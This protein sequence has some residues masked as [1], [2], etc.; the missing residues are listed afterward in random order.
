MESKTDFDN[1]L[2]VLVLE[3][4]IKEQNSTI[5]NMKG[6]INRLSEESEHNKINKQVFLK[7]ADS[8]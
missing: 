6:T 7:R 3:F 2:G 8:P 1:R 5:K 4:T